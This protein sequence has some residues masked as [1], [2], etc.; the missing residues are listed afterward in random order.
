MG[1]HEYEDGCT[2]YDAQAKHLAALFRKNFKA[3]ADAVSPEVVAAGPL[4]G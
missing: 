4:L 1:C 3:Y 2:H